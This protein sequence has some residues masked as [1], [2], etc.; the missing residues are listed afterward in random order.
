VAVD[1]S[2]G[3]T[4]CV[5]YGHVHVAVAVNAHDHDHVNVNVNVNE[6]EEAPGPVG[7]GSFF[8]DLLSQK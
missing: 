5:A 8:D 2:A 4:R 6:L 7:R 1:D 3:S